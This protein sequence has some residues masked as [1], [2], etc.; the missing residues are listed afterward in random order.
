MC[1]KATE[2]AEKRKDKG[3]YH[4]HNSK[5]FYPSTISPGLMRL[6]EMENHEIVR[7]GIIYALRM[8]VSSCCF[9]MVD[10]S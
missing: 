5:S 2:C 6:W 4:M 1:P 3:L 9:T 8:R 7:N 10:M